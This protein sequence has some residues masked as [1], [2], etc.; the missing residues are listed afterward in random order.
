MCRPHPA[1]GRSY[2]D[3][4]AAGGMICH[5][6]FGPNGPSGNNSAL[7]GGVQLL[8]NVETSV[9]GFVAVEVL[10]AGTPVAGMSV[11]D[12]DAVK[13]SSVRAI[14]SWGKGS[15]RTL[16]HLAGQQVQLRV[17]MAD[18]KLFAIRLACAP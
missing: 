16:S 6:L 2:C 10:Q 17:V 14:G 5:A 18:A 4:G 15:L 3:T 8:L 11:V 12:S 7:E 9:I 13:G 1:D